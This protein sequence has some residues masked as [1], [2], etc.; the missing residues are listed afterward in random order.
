MNDEFTLFDS[1][2][3]PTGCMA[4]MRITVGKPVGRALADL[5]GCVYW[6]TFLMAWKHPPMVAHL[7]EFATNHYLLVG[8]FVVLLVLLIIT[9]ARKG[10]RSLSTGELTALV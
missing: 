2:R 3:C 6:P 5:G 4:W 9:E 7:I 8:I 1:E 10:G